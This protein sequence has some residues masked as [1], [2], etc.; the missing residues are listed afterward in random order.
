MLAASI[1]TRIGVVWGASAGSDYIRV[2]SVTSQI[3]INTGWASFQTGFPPLNFTPVSGGGTPPFGQD[4]NG[5][6]NAITAWNQWQAAG[7]Q[8]TF[9]TAF[10]IAIS[11]YPKGAILASTTFGKGW[12]NLAD[13]NT[14]DPD[15]TPT[16]WQETSIFGGMTTG[17]AKLTIK[18][19]ADT[20]WIIMND[21]TIGDASSGATTRANA[22]T[23]AL[24]ALLWANV[25]NTYAAVS[26][27]RGA[28]AAADYAAHKTIQCGTILGRS[29]VVGGAGA[30]LTARA[31]LETY[32]AQ[33]ITIL[34]QNL[35]SVN[36]TH[37]GTTLSDPTHFHTYSAPVVSG[38]APAFSGSGFGFT[39]SNTSAAS[40]GI[41]VSAQGS[42]AS[43]GSSTAITTLDPSA[44]FNVMMK[45]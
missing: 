36:F 23:A 37:S 11:G 34:Q 25:S 8:I 32:G 7:A 38:S 27:G 29:L 39:T 42:A 45:L 10:S 15:S 30:G 41:S 1:P 16:N 18:T 13:G 21:G 24:F 14:N 5:V 19:T 3:G 6:L 35:P 40:T 33:T 28:S 9:N 26:G 22:D 31:L 44:A 43:G 4:F 12:I 17:D 2:V 20:G